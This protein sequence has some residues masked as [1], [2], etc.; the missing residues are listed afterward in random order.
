M[1]NPV[2]QEAAL[3]IAKAGAVSARASP[4]SARAWASVA[5]APPR[6]RASPSAE[7]DGKIRGIAIILAAFIEGV[8]LFAVVL[9]LLIDRLS[10][11]PAGERHLEFA[12]CLGRDRWR[13]SRGPRRALGIL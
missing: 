12:A 11:I 13:V 6:R 1:I 10:P 8:A 5:S 3:D 7:A 2:V 9:T 4:P